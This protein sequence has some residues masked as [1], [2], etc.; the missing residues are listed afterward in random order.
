MA[1]SYSYELQAKVFDRMTALEAKQTP[2]QSDPVL[3]CL[4]QRLTAASLF[5]IPEHLAQIEATKEVLKLHGVDFAPLL[6]IAPAQQ[7]ILREEESLEPT[8]LGKTIGYTGK[9]FNLLLVASG[10]QVKT[11]EGWFPTEEGKPYATV[12]SWA[13]GAKSGYNLKWRRSVLKQ[14]DL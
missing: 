5:K 14:L 4:A 2:A 6:K 11:V 9:D 13:K 7:N 3:A 1:M 8:D 10:M 12:H